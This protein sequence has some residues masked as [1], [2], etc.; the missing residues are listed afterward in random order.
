VP[1]DF[2]W[3]D[4]GYTLLHTRREE[5]F[6]SVLETFGLDRPPGKIDMAFHHTDKTFMREY[7]GMLGR[8]PEQFMC[9]YVGTLCHFLDIRADTVA[10]CARWME[11]W[12]NQSTLWHAYPCA[13]EVLERLA[14]EG[15]RLGVISNWDASAKPILCRCGLIDLFEH[16]II[17]SEVGTA[18]PSKAIFALALDRAGLPADRCLYVGDN[19][20]D[21]AVGAA[22][23]GMKTLIVN[24]LGTFGV[25]ELEGQEIIPDISSILP[26]LRGDG[27]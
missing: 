24:R 11:S 6:G 18:K 8:P 16:C 9:L 19:Y 7:P 22:K 1:Y 23:V 12:Q 5:L 25:E 27:A 14:A 17:S 20:Y 4:L 10:I 21:D 13:R 3:F 2:I 26:L 15:L